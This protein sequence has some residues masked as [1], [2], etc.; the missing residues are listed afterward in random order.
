MN[1]NSAAH[2]T[3]N[4]FDSG[5]IPDFC[6][7]QAILLTILCT[8]VLAF[9]VALIKAENVLIDW[10][11]LGITSLFL[12]A[13]ILF[14]V[15]VLCLTRPLLKLKSSTIQA[16]SIMLV[17]VSMCAAL[18]WFGSYLFNY[19]FNNALI[20]I[21]RNTL[22]IGM[23]CGLA[24]RYIYLDYLAKQ[25][26]KA[27]L[28]SRIEAL[29]SRIRPHFLFNSMNTIASLIVSKPDKAENA[30]LDLSELFR[31]TLNTQHSYVTIAEELALCRKYLNIESL[32]LGDRLNIE[33][34][35]DDEVMPFS[36]PP[37]T[38]QPIVEN[39]I[40]HGIQPTQQGGTIRFEGYIKQDCVYI[41]VSNPVAKLEA[42]HKGNKIALSNIADRLSALYSQQALLK[43]SQF[44]NTFTATVRI[45]ARK[46]RN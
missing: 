45:P 39:A 7:L 1:S 23:L 26:E 40:Y 46:E 44:D 20:F 37:L 5:F 30:V 41:L 36:I 24:L 19:N 27:Q 32:R 42:T 18:S 43:T 25:R 4:S 11:V 15:A 21:T 31:A 10:Q 2:S 22:V 29:Q 17:V 13:V 16:T 34:A 9:V 38:L 12:Y 35:I 8:Q 28:Q 3:D 6:N 33:W 14:S